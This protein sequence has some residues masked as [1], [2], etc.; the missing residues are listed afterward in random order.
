MQ[1]LSTSER[2]GVA[3]AQGGLPEAGRL[4]LLAEGYGAFGF[5]RT[6][7]PR[8]ITYITEQKQRHASNNL[9]ASLEKQMNLPPFLSPSEG[10]PV[11]NEPLSDQLQLLAQ[12]LLAQ[13]Y[14]YPAVTPTRRKQSGA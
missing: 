4:L 2:R 7:I 5:A 9:W 14:S 1:T 8:I 11:R 6:E 3:S 13:R 10:R 12:R